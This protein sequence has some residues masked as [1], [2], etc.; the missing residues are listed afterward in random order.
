M[1]ILVL[2]I[3]NN[4]GE[5]SDD[6]TRDWPRLAYECLG[7]SSRGEGW[8]WP[9]AGSGALGVALCAWDVLKEV[10]VTFIHFSSVQLLS[11]VQLCDPMDRST[12]GFP[13]LHQLPELSQNSCPSSRWCHP[14]ISSSVIP[15][16]SFLQ[17]SPSIRVFSSDSV[18][19][20]RWPE[21]WSF[22]FSIT[23]SNGYSG[24][25]SFRID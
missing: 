20:I 5:R 19:H 3:N 13:I 25:I 10:T 9:A 8:Q 15:F 16:S 21:Y 22:S 11:C 2:I 23:P 7:V 12:R 14:T 6:P 17:S 4:P 1:G 18:L 24:R